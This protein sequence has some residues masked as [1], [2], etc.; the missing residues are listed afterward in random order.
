MLLNL[1]ERTD[2]ATSFEM[3]KESVRT[4]AT[5]FNQ[6]A[7]SQT[8]ASK[9]N[10]EKKDQLPALQF[11]TISYRFNDVRLSPKLHRSFTITLT[12]DKVRKV[13]DSYGVVLFERNA[14]SNVKVLRLIHDI[15]LKMVPHLT[16]D[17]F[18]RSE[19]EGGFSIE[20]ELYK[21]NFR[22]FSRQIH[23]YG[24][25][26]KVEYLKKLENLLC[27]IFQDN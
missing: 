24:T 6:E 18:G 20:L 23:S 11:D 16:P 5:L 13:V 15:I 14:P 10:V 19:N 8:S 12:D 26:Q 9:R 3:A 21:D 17:V 7:G 4:G 27:S 22:V 25:P 1:A 2:K